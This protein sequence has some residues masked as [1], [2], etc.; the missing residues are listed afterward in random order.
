MG[1]PVRI[2]S[3][4]VVTSQSG[5][6]S[7]ASGDV[8]LLPDGG[9]PMP[10]MN[11]ALSADA[12]GTARAV[13]VNGVPVMLARSTFARSTGDEPGEDGG[14]ISHATRGA[15]VFSNY[16]F[17]VRIEGQPVP[18]ALDPM[19]HN[20]DRSG[21]PNAAS[22]AELQAVASMDPELDII[23]FAICY[24]NAAGMKM[25][26]FRR[27]LATPLQQQVPTCDIDPDAPPGHKSCVRHWDPHNPPGFY[28]EPAY[29][30][31]PPPPTPMLG[32]V[33]SKTMK[34]AH[35][36]PLPL[37][38]GDLPPLPG[39]R[40]PDVVVPLDPTKPPGPGNIKRIF[41]V[42]FPGDRL[43]PGQEQA[44][45]EIARPLGTVQV[46]GPEDCECDGK[47]RPQP[48]EVP[49]PVPLPKKQ[50]QEEEEAE[51]QTRPSYLVNL[52]VVVVG[53][54]L[55]GAMLGGPWGAAG[56]AAAGVV[57]FIATQKDEEPVA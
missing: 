21:V 43:R 11:V 48:Q 31:V 2:N 24:C 54:A 19:L 29:Q 14:V 49:L 26:C 16:S 35:G 39:T 57:V 34:D 41:E 4:E 25:D 45:K 22:P 9:G 23:C 17:D 28:V 55:A 47:H 8:C 36:D 32:S 13:R 51:P 1:G 3:R 37:P 27:L 15:A 30:M 12:A 20:L 42:K 50:P 44:Y 10:F 46:V 18:R 40:R 33:V 52:T 56:G 53:C 5:G 7:Y 6:V 38:G